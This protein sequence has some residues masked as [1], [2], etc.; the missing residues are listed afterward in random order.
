L[1]KF[2][3]TVHAVLPTESFVLGVSLLGEGKL[4]DGSSYDAISKELDSLNEG[5]ANNSEDALIAEIAMANRYVLLTTDFHLYQVAQIHGIGVI[6]WM[7]GSVHAR[8]GSAK[9]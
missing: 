2:A 6:Y 1:E 5:K 8:R 4:G 7:S 9:C 3:E